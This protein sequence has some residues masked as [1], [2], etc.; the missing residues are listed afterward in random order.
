MTGFQVDPAAL[1][2]TA[3]GVQGVMDELGQLGINGEQT[4]GS[5]VINLALSR[6]DAGD[7]L[8]STALGQVLDRAHYVLRDLLGNAEQMVTRLQTN[9]THYQQVEHDVADKFREL[10]SALMGGPST[11]GAS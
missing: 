10:G 2:V 11:G 6:D 4:S 8:V 9:R 7:E 3:E 5:P 1:A